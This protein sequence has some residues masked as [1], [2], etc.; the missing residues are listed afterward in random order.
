[1]FRASVFD[2]Y[3]VGKVL[4]LLKFYEMENLNEIKLKLIAKICKSKNPDLIK[5]LLEKLKENSTVVSEPNS[6]YENEKP[7]TDEQVENYFKEDEIVL[8]KSVMEMVEKGMEDVKNGR[9]SDNEEVEKYFE[10]W[11]KD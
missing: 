4:P 7:L 2:S 8:P 3:F 10:E 6:V 5:A 1:M 9:V 11:L